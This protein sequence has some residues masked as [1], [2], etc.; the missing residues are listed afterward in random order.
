M[1]GAEF[2]NGANN[3]KFTGSIYENSCKLQKMSGNELVLSGNSVINLATPVLNQM[4][5]TDP[6]STIAAPGVF[7]TCF[8]DITTKQFPSKTRPV[9]TNTLLNE[10]GP[11]TVTSGAP[12]YNNVV[13]TG[14][15]NVNVKAGAMTMACTTAASITSGAAMTLKAGAVMKLTGSNIY[16]N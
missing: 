13:T 5:N 9:P 3:T 7:T 11:V 1:Q 10:L 12:G 15:F 4:I 2:S 16:L 6:T 8:G 14:L